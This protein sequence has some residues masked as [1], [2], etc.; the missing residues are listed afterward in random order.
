M[1]R[2]VLAAATLCLAATTAYADPFAGAY[3]NTVNQTT[4]DGKTYKIYVNQ[5]GTWESV[6]AEGDVKGTFTWKDATHACFV[7][8]NPVPKD[9][10]KTDGCNEIKGEHK[11][12]D[13]WTE[14]LPNNAGSIAMS[15]TAGR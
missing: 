8:T 9:P 3:G 4:P 5:D 7:Q 10:S 2:F 13:S 15:I 1:K 6:S 14:T 11:A 12:G